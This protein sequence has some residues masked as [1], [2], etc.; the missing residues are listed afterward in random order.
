MGHQTRP[1]RLPGQLI[2]RRIDDVDE[3]KSRGCCR[4]TRTR[5]IS[6]AHQ[7]DDPLDRLLATPDGHQGTGDIAHHVVQEGI[8][9]DVDHDQLAVTTHLDEMHVASWRAR[10]TTCRTEGREVQ[11]PYQMGGRRLHVGDIQ[12]FT[13]PGGVVTLHHRPKRLIDDHVAITTRDGAESGMEVIGNGDR[14]MDTD[15]RGK[16]DV[17]A[18]APCLAAA[19]HGGIEV[20]DL[21]H[22]VHT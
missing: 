8:R 4:G 5:A 3:V 18:H 19:A 7:L 11:L 15:I 6:P 22:G 21:T 12:G 17:A 9:L 16:I 13:T 10:L 2:A 20:H 14:P 1:E